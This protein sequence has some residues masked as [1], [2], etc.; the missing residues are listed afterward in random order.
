[1]SIGSAP[2][3]NRV[4]WGP[5]REGWGRGGRSM[6]SAWPHRTQVRERQEGEGLS[7]VRHEDQ[8]VETGGG[9]SA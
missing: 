2:E 5:E 9:E 7:K 8:K 3:K 4:H 6:G 1:M